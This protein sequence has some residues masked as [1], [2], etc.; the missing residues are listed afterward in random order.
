[1]ST[2]TITSKGQITISKSVRE[3]L[4]V[5]SGDRVGFVEMENGSFQ[6]VVSTRDVHSLKGSVPKLKRAVSTG[7][8]K[9]TIE[10]RLKNRG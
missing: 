8:M 5:S 6:L 1:M 9:K 7:A 10:T 3:R 4:G 2:A